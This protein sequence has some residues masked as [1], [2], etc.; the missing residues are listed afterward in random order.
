M[1]ELLRG[2]IIMT[3]KCAVIGNPIAHSLSPQ[4][5]HQFAA[6]FGM[7]L[8]YEKILG[9]LEHFEQ[10]V[11][12]FFV[13]GGRGLNVTLPFKQRA[14]A[15]ASQATERCRLAKAANTLW[16]ED[17][18]LQAD[19]TDGVGFVRDISRF[20]K[21]ENKAILILGAGGATRGILGPLLNA[22]P[23]KIVVAN[24]TQSKAIELKEDFPKIQ[25]GEITGR[26][27][28]IINATSASLDAQNLA[29]PE[30]LFTNKPF[31]YDL[32]YNQVEM[33]PFVKLAR[34]LGCKACDG[35]GMLVAQAAEAFTIWHGVRPQL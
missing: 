28:L 29:L 30:S 6:Q 9:D 35:L 10:Q 18:Q 3:I 19:N 4:I 21:L 20:I 33:T 7:D 13:S 5:H 27:D 1:V 25:I 34:S 24:R 14:F 12:D 26:Y 22:K 16:M 15:M 2:E 11:K 17:G 32:A 8:D 31:C 23:E